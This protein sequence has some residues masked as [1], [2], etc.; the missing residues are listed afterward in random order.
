MRLYLFLNATAEMNWCAD[1]VQKSLFPHLYAPVSHTISSCTSYPTASLGIRLLKMVFVLLCLMGIQMLVMPDAVAALRDPTMPYANASTEGTSSNE[2][3]YVL[4][5]ILISPMRKLAMING[6]LVGVGSEIQ[7]ARILVISKNHVV[8]L[9]SG[10]KVII[11]LFG[12]R[13]WTAH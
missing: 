5:S 11:Y 13:L 4:Q 1:R 3:S 7:G 6:K 10:R 2:D 12:R 9:V 8:L